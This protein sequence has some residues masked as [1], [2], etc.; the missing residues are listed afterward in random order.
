LGH[1]IPKDARKIMKTKVRDLPKLNNG[2]Q[3]NS[4]SFIHLGLIEGI[5][6]K[7]MNA[8]KK[9]M[10]LILHLILMVYRS[11]AVAARNLANCLSHY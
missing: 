11:G 8:D 5:R 6:K 1:N 3:C 9:L 2:V 10:V 7:L 4:N